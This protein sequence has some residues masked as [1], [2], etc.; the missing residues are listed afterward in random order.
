VE[1]GN[2]SHSTELVVKTEDLRLDCPLSASA[3]GKGEEVRLFFLLLG[4]LV[5]LR[6]WIMAFTLAE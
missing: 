3:A 2:K 6:L 4:L 1:Q 5:E